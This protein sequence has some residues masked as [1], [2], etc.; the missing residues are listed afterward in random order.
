M[1]FTNSNVP[2]ARANYIPT[3]TTLF[4]KLKQFFS[5]YIC[6]SFSWLFATDF[7]TFGVKPQNE[8]FFICCLLLELVTT[9]MSVD[10]FFFIVYNAQVRMCNE[11]LCGSDAGTR[12]QSRYQMFENIRM[13]ANE[14]EYV[15][16]FGAPSFTNCAMCKANSFS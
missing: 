1:S 15:H 9:K 6:I 11:H 2:S 4:V 10:F 12:G 8:P 3:Y 14:W 7:T 5:L 13:F 16:R